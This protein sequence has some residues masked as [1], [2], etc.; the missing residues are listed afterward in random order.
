[1][2]DLSKTTISENALRRMA[3][4]FV[5][6]IFD[7]N[8]MNFDVFNDLIGYLLILFALSALEWEHSLFKK[9]KW[10]T[11]VLFIGSII[12]VWIPDVSMMQWSPVV[13][14][15]YLIYGQLYSILNLL[16]IVLL[17]RA[18]GQL[19]IW[20]QIE[21]EALVVTFKTRRKALIGISVLQLFWY[22]FIMNMNEDWAIGIFV[23]AIIQ[24]FLMFL[25][26]RILF[27]LANTYR[28]YH[29]QNQSSEM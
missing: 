3:W 14:L 24:V 21:D 5:L 13:P 16:M 22:P 28:L 27:R 23:L 15:H 4:G 6:L 18:L 17:F 19:S 9:V 7:F 8:I 25:F 11:I 2:T 29:E 20:H 26:V 12:S 1:M 10:I